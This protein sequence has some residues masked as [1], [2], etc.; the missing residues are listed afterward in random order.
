[1]IGSGIAGR[2]SASTGIVLQR[3]KPVGADGGKDE[4]LEIGELCQ[5][6]RAFP[7]L[8]DFNTAKEFFSHSS[9]NMW[10]AEEWLVCSNLY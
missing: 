6:L 5:T 10:D 2:D 9:Y 1:M 4:I 3:V 8:R 7:W